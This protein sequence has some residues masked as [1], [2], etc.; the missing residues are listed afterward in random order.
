MAELVIGIGKAKPSKGTSKDEPMGGE[1]ASDAELDSVDA[2]LDDAWAA[3]KAD[4][5]DAFKSAM[6]AAI[7]AKCAEMYEDR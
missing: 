2:A 7:S 3:V 4:D 1:P 6:S 5:P